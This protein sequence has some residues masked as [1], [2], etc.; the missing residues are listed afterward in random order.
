MKIRVYRS[1]EFK[2]W[3]DSLCD[4]E[5]RNVLSR[6]DRYEENGVLIQFKPLDNRHHL[7][8][9]KWKSGL[10][11]YFTLQV[12]LDGNFT[13]LLKGGNKN[14]QEHDISESK[15]IILAAMISIH[16]KKNIGERK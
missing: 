6:I 15:R 11:V 4:R 8:E 3:F 14:S 7:F 16:R 12:D 5:Q 2:E 13:L 9:F 1:K 10:R